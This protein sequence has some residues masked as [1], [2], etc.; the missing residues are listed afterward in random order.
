MTAGARSDQRQKLLRQESPEQHENPPPQLKPLPRQLDEH[1]P[2]KHTSPEQQVPAPAL[3]HTPPAPWHP[4][5][6]HRPLEHERPE[7]HV[8]IDEQLLPRVPHDEV[9]RQNPLVH[10]PLQHCPELAHDA[11]SE[12]HALDRHDPLVQMPEQHSPWVPHD[13]P[14]ALQLVVERHDPD[15]QV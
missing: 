3:P 4:P 11:P 13:A 12:R 6:A 9:E 7:Q 2:P 5:D 1:D 14:V 8:A 15:A 10:E